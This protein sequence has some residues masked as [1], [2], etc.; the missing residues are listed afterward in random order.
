MDSEMAVRRSSGVY[1]PAVAGFW[2]A[3]GRPG[4]FGSPDLGLQMGKE[5]MKKQNTG[6]E[7]AGQTA[8]FAALSKLTRPA[9]RA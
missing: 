2:G 6:M 1:S 3:A 9:P 4:L 7:A 5:K 8:R